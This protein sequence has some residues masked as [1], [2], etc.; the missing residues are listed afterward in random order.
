MV[1]DEGLSLSPSRVNAWT[2][3]AVRD[4]A[5]AHGFEFG[6]GADV[7]LYGVPDTLRPSYGAHPVSAHLFIRVRP[8]TGHMGRMWNMRMGGQM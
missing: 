8:P 2:L 5:V 4:L 1:I 7:L 3:G 6:L